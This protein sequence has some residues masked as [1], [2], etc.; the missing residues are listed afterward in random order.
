MNSGVQDPNTTEQMSDIPMESPEKL[1][2]GK[3]KSMATE[4]DPM[5]DDEDESEEDEEV[6]LNVHLQSEPLLTE[7]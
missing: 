2:K 7:Q 4:Q 6:T 1:E 3:G 5:E